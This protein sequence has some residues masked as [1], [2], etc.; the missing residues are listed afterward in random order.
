MK[1]TLPLLLLAL[2]AGCAGFF[3]Y[4]GLAGKDRP[5]E[6]VLPPLPAAPQAAAMVPDFALPDVAGA[7]RSSEEWSDTI[8]VV[9]FWAT[10]CPPCVREIPLLVDIQAEY[11]ERGVQVI[12]I[13]IDETDAV[14]DFANGFAFNYPVLVGQEDAMELGHRFVNGFIGLPFTVFAGRDG[15]IHRVHTGEIHRE[16]IEAILAELL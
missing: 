10:W 4:L 7:Q 2:A 13:A 15:R 1:Q 11:A 5:V 12:G 9:N 14:A 8:R 16:Q 6:Q 3:L